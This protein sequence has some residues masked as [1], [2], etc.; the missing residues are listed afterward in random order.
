ML[1]LLSGCHPCKSLTAEQTIDSTRV[2]Y[3]ERTVYVPDTILVSIPLQSA[4]RTTA[5][6][7]SHL[8][9]EYAES[10]AR[11]N[12]DGTLYHSLLTKPQEKAVPTQRK[13]TE[14]E[15]TVYK[16]R[17]ITKTKTVTIEKKESFW[18]RARNA[19]ILGLFFFVVLLYTIKKVRT[20]IRGFTKK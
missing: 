16:N 11:I 17:I 15:K 14:K 18:V 10:D 6:S 8:E 19:A 4:E 9:N 7:V 1:V 12:T 3:R 20:H 2:E 13:E 5:D